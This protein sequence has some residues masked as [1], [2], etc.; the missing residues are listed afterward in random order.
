MLINVIRALFIVIIIAIVFVNINKISQ[1]SSFP[2]GLDS[3]MQQLIRVGESGNPAARQ[4]AKDVVEYLERQNYEKFFVAIVIGL[5]VVIAAIVIDWLTPKRSLSSLAGIFFGLLVGIFISWAMSWVLDM[6]NKTYS[7]DMGEGALQTC[8]LLMGVSICYLVIV[9]V[10]RTKDDFRFVIP[11]VEFTKQIKGQRPLVL[12][13][14]VIIDGRIADLCQTKLFDAPLVVPKFVLNELQF[15][16]DSADKLK[17]NRGRRGLDMLN[18]LQTN[19][20]IEVVID[21]THISSETAA[22]VDQKLL[23]F[24]KNVDGRLVTNDYNLSKVAM[25]RSVDIININDLANSL[26]PVV[27]PGEAMQVKII[28]GGEE[29]QQGI[30]YLDDGTMVVVEDARDSIG[31]TIPVTITSSLQTSAGRMIFGKC[32]RGGSGDSGFGG[33]GGSRRYGGTP[34]RKRFDSDNG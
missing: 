3:S 21:D 19:P 24:T 32:E 8:K 17:R 15:I 7:V 13:T 4:A 16:A 12:D 22:D 1:S 11:Y 33:N 27:L 14:S 34:R 28:K 18:K 26:K 5:V 2:E 31:Q 6:L 23:V 20:L 9:F 29:A 30:G 25:L 10:I